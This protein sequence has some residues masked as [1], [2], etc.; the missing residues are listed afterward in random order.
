MADTVDIKDAAGATK[1]VATDDV[2]NVHYQRVKLVDGTL[3]STVAITSTS[4]GALNVQET[5]L[6]GSILATVVT[7]GTTAVTLPASALSGRRAVLIQSDPTNTAYIYIGGSAVTA[8][9]ASTG[10]FILGPGQSFSLSLAS[11]LVVYGRS[12]SASQV[13]RVVEVS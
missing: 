5:S 1:A 6:A 8:D 11:G 10:G 4:G 3:D 9:G 12:T 7:V 2:S 13:V